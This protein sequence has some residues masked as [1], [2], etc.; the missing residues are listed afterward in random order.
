[1]KQVDGMAQ[2]R[3]YHTLSDWLAK[4]LFRVA[5]VTHTWWNLHVAEVL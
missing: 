1:M 4:V 5:Q 3:P 2:Q